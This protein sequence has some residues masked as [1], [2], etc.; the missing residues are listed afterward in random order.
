MSTP[1]G[2]SS[3]VAGEEITLEKM[4]RKPAMMR[5]LE[6]RKA[7]EA[8]ERDKGEIPGD[9]LGEINVFLS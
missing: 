3:S 2:S 6:A 5:A 8:E 7:G 9:Q 4:D 1:L